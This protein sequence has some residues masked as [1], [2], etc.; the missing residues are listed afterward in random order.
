MAGTVLTPWA[1]LLP[2]GT[3]P[4]Y[5]TGPDRWPDELPVVLALRL[6]ICAPRQVLAEPIDE[7]AHGGWCPRCLFPSCRVDTLAIYAPLT[8]WEALNCLECGWN[9]L[10]RLSSTPLDVV[11]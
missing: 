11:V 5:Y 8:T 1:H 4:R 6:S 2:R 3:D 7:H 9:R 10:I